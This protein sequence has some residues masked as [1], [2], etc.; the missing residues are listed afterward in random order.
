MGKRE[1]LLLAIFAVLGIVVYQVT[2]PPPPP[3]SQGFSLS[4]LIRNARRHMNGNRESASAHTQA[5]LAAG[6]GI[7][8]LRVNI[9]RGSAITITGESR[10]DIAAD[11]QVTARGYD[12]PEAQ[13]AA[14][15]SHV[16]LEAAGDAAVVSVDMPRNAFVPDVTLNLKIPKRLSVRLNSH[17]GRLAISDVAAVDVDASRGETRIAR[18]A[19][20]LSITQSVG[21]LEIVDAGALK[22]NTRNSRGTVRSVRGTVSIQSIGGE[23]TM[24]DIAGPID[25]DARNTELQLEKLAPLKPPLR[26]QATNGRLRISDL[27][28][29]ARLDVNNSEVDVALDAPAP[30]TIYSTGETVTLTPPPG[31]YTLDATANEGRITIDDGEI[32]PSEN[33]GEQHAQGAVR[34]G[35]PAIMLRATRGDIVVRARGN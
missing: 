31:G 27:R 28:T 20:R 4:G 32:K 8:E 10:A 35:G 33:E 26:V 16:K 19:G 9:M 7:R 24:I 30:L 23:L 13:A 25:I 6:T 17:F 34:G 21:D 11:F 3:G 1:L 5:S 29:E 12:R 15:A 2:A 22:L 18:I 14:D